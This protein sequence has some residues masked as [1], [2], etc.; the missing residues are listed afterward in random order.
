IV[1]LDI[2]LPDMSGIE[3][4]RRIKG[5]EVLAAVPVLQVSA[6]AITDGDRV[7]G[8]EGGADAYLTEP[9]DSD[10]LAATL[11]ALMRARRAELGLKAASGGSSTSCSTRQHRQRQAAA[12]DGAGR[13]GGHC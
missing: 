2:N 6:T 1:L 4:C 5:D 13:S 8:L 7:R 12:R 3:V 11:H 9:A 10:V